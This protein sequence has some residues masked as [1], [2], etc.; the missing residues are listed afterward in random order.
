MSYYYMLI[1]R[2]RCKDKERLPY[3][4]DDMRLGFVARCNPDTHANLWFFLRNFPI[5]YSVFLAQRSLTNSRAP[6]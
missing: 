3:K 4:S 1:N 2:V 6:R 5:V